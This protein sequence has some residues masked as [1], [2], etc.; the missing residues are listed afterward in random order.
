MPAVK[1]VLALAQNNDASESFL[2]EAAAFAARHEAHLIALTIGR[3]ETI[4]YAGLPDLPPS[5]YADEMAAVRARVE[6]RMAAAT[7][8]LTA[9]GVSFEVRG[10]VVPAGEAGR[11][12]AAQARY[13]DIALLP[14]DADCADIA[15]AALFASGRPVLI[16]PPGASFAG[17]GSRVVIAWDP[18]AEATRAAHDAIT[19]MAGAEEVRVVVVDPRVGPGAHG[20]E[21]GSGLATSLARHGLPVTVDSIPSAGLSVADAIKRQAAAASADLIV[22]GAYGHSRLTEIILGGVTRDLLAGCDRPLLMA[23]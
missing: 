23:H 21:P 5:V 16:V 22:S 19:L 18:G 1:T 8:T 17:I 2:K 13:A 3:Q 14:R 20:E 9:T 11:T 15:D 6:T 10:A 7:Q 4:A 12:F